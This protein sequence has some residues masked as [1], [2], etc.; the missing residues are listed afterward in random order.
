MRQ[1]NTEAYMHNRLRMNV[2]SYL[3]ANL[4][5]DYRKGE[6]YFAE[7]LVDWDLENN[8]N[9]WEPS[10]TYDLGRTYPPFVFF[11]EHCIVSEFRNGLSTNLPCGNFSLRRRL[12]QNCELKLCDCL[13][14]QQSHWLTGAP[15]LSRYDLQSY[16]PSRKMRQG[17]RIYTEM[18]AGAEGCRRQSD[19]C[20]IRS[21]VRRRIQ[22]VGISQ[23][24]CQLR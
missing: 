4:L 3:R 15:E 6:R 2:S 11:L 18:G 17:R 16:H 23:A 7:H 22:Q 1:L 13:C 20:T 14:A 8:T 9:G 10:C 5:I 12:R 24:T 21:I 19:I